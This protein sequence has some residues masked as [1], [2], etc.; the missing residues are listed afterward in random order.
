MRYWRLMI[1][2]NYTA[3]RSVFPQAA[4]VIGADHAGCELGIHHIPLSAII[5]KAAGCPAKHHRS[6]TDLIFPS[7]SFSS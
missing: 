4:V 2:A 5:T 6:R 3:Y 7:K 1:E